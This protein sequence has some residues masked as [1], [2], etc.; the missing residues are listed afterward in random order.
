MAQSEI[1]KLREKVEKDPNSKLFVPLAEEYRKAGM[2]D[3]AISVLQKGIERQPSYM[4][5]RVSLGKIYLEKMMLSEARAEF[6]SVVS[7]I[8][9]NLY[10]HKKLAEICRDTGDRETAMREFRTV[11]RLNAM[12]D[13]AHAS[14]RQLE[15]EE[16]VSDEY[17]THESATEGISVE[18]AQAEEGPVSEESAGELTFEPELPE[19]TAVELSVEEVFEDVPAAD[20]FPAEQVVGSDAVKEDLDNFAD[21]LFGEKI[22]TDEEDSSVAAQP[23]E[24]LGGD[25]DDETF[26]LVD[27]ATEDLSETRAFFAETEELAAGPASAGTPVPEMMEK[28]GFDLDLNM[29]DAVLELPA[30]AESGISETVEGTSQAG[31]EDAD[32]LVSQGEYSAAIKLYK[33]IV[34]ASPGD[35]KT[36]QRLAE[37]K[38]LLKLLGKDKESLIEELNAFQK[39]IIKRRDEFFRS[40]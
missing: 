21:A 8:P 19:D 38:A 3:E 5:A 9:D 20:F 39:G 29:P 25:L 11:L 32:R 30:Y 27:E 18:E 23:S 12:D 6:E 35:N 26:E 37:L 15:S 2:V 1:E 17:V 36:L 28:V 13:D 14:L 4:S 7:A 31:L 40:S 24:A 33:G 16:F 10:A 22:E 34:A